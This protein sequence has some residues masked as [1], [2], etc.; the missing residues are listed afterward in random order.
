MTSMENV[1]IGSG[2]LQGRGV[3]AKRDFLMGEVVVEYRLMP[4]T[5][6]E[7]DLLP[8]DE[9][10][11]THTQHG[12]T[13]LYGVPERYVN[14]SDNPNTYQDFEVGADIALR[15]IKRDEMITTDATKDDV[16]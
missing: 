12:Q 15:D 7:L 9:R 10:E 11:F 14:H 3:Y 5:Q 16:N 8:E 1:Y 6:E 13:H 2:E 4:L